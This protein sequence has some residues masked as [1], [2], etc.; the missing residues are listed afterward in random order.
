[1]L[2]EILFTKLFKLPGH[3]HAPKIVYICHQHLAD[4][5]FIPPPPEQLAEVPN[6]ICYEERNNFV[7]NVPV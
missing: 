6:G 5:L 4:F 7:G 1:M 3:W 2:L